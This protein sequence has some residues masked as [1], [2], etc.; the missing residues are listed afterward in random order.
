MLF[1][2]SA[3]TSNGIDWKIAAAQAEEAEHHKVAKTHDDPRVDIIERLPDV[4]PSL[5]EGLLKHFGSLSRLFAAEVSDLRKVEGIGPK[6]AEKIFTF[7]NGI[8]AA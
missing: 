6:R 8:K 1:M 5:A 4:G 3:Q 2:L 7:L